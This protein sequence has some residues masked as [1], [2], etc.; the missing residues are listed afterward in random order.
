LTAHRKFAMNSQ[1]LLY[2]NKKAP[3]GGPLMGQVFF[4]F[5][6]RFLCRPLPAFSGAQGC[7]FAA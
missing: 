7:T 2:L 6:A 5:R 4:S 1:S 3:N